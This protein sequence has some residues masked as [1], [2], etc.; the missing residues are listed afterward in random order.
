MHAI[1]APAA[2]GPKRR[3]QGFVWVYSFYCGSGLY[4]LYYI[5]ARCKPCTVM[6]GGRMLGNDTNLYEDIF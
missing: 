1:F 2:A 4:A 5:I 6:N 3:R